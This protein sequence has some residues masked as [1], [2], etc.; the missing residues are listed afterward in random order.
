M[1]VSYILFGRSFMRLKI[2]TFVHVLKPLVGLMKRLSRTTD[3]EFCGRVLSF[4]AAVLPLSD[5]SG[6]NKKGAINTGNVTKID[7]KVKDIDSSVDD[8][9]IDV[10]FW[11]YV[12]CRTKNRFLII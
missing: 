6:T 2:P 11:K 4:T 8:T 3:T 5:P 1:L 12:H 10:Q 7:E 9:P